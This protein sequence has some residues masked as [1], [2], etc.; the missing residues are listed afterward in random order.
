MRGNV[1]VRFGGR[2]GETHRPTRRQGAPVRPLHSPDY[3]E[4]A[5]HRR[6]ASTANMVAAVGKE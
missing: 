6:A 3:Q 1:H 2:A 4:L 5:A